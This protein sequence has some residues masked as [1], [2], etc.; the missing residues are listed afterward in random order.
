MNNKIATYLPEY[1]TPAAT[2]AGLPESSLPQ[3]FAGITL[4]DFSA[5]PGISD[6][7]IA[8]VGP[9]VKHAYVSSFK[10]V[11]YTTIPFSV[12]LIAA[13]CFVPNMEKF[14]GNNV[15]KRLQNFKGGDAPR[16]GVVGSGKSTESDIEMKGADPVEVDRVDKA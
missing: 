2:S 10:I 1:V 15:A 14:L 11:F 13:A 3:L 12:L 8:A 6:E 9:A 7:V 4:G 16:S 5:V